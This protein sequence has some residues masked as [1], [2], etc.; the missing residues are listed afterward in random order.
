MVQTLQSGNQGTHIRPFLGFGVSTP[1]TQRSGKLTVIHS[2]VINS[3]RVQLYGA[4]SQQKVTVVLKVLFRI[5]F[6]DTQDP[7]GSKKYV[8]FRVTDKWKRGKNRK[9]KKMQATVDFAYGSDT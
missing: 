4:I 1:C 6:I 8:M 9:S 2:G 3:C 7:T 5:E